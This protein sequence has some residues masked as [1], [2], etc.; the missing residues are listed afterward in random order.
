MEELAEIMSSPRGLGEPIPPT[1][2]RELPRTPTFRT[3]CLTITS[4]HCFLV[5][6][7]VDYS[8]KGLGINTFQPLAV[9]AEVSVTG[10]VQVDGAWKEYSGLA[11][12]THCQPKNEHLFRVG[13]DFER[14]SWKSVSDPSSAT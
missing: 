4:E 1:E 7:L 8:P 3:H 10:T 6:L 14:S 13:L 5:G 12:V 9:D 2:Q 11:R